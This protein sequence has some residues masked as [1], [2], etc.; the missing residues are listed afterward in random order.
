MTV[1]VR[2]DWTVLTLENDSAIKF[3]ISTTPGPGPGYNSRRSKR[4]NYPR[5]SGESMLISEVLADIMIADQRTLS[6][7]QI[8]K[9]R[10]SITKPASSSAGKFCPASQPTSFWNSRADRLIRAES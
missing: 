5:Y 9:Q 4:G 6:V 1:V 7:S 2:Q 10:S 8:G 3:S